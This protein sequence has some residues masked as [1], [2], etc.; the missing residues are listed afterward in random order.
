MTVVDPYPAIAT[1]DIS[2]GVVSATL[3]ALDPVRHRGVEAGVFWLGRRQAAARVEAVVVP[4]GDGVEGDRG[5]WQVS[6][7]VFG[8]VSRWATSAGVSLLA[9]CH[10]HGGR[11]PAR[12][13]RIDRTHGV[14]APGV[15]SIVIAHNGAEADP[16]RWG[17][18]V[19]RDGDYCVL[20]PADR[21]QRLHLEG[22]TTPTLW[23][24][25]ATGT[26]RA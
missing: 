23:R 5:H 4:N 20:S 16:Q 6:T 22:E 9:V 12:L 24:A 3:D 18:Y 13:S 10:T 1:W 17:W 11:S 8:Q 14:K 21:S 26:Y 2:S 25:D 7:A 19:W 15:L